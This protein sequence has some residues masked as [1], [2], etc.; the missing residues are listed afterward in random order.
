MK[1]KGLDDKLAL[2][3]E[4]LDH[5]ETDYRDEQERMK[6]REALMDG[7]K[8]ILSPDGT[9]SRK[10]AK[11]VRNV[12]LEMVETQ[13]DSSIPPPKVTALREEDEELATIIEAM[14]RNVLDRLQFERMNDEA[15]RI[16]PTQGGHGMLA[17]WRSTVSGRGWMGDLSVTMLHPRKIVPQ[18]G[19][20]QVQEMDYIFIKDAVTKRQVKE[21][22]HVNVDGEREDDPDARAVGASALASD[23]L[24]TLVTVYYRNEHG[25]I[26]R[27]RFVGDTVCEDMEDYQIRRVKE[28]RACGAIGNGKKCRY[29]GAKKFDEK[30]LEYEELT[31]DIVTERGNVIPM[32]S[33]EVD[34]F[35]QT[36]MED[37]P[38]E[39]PELLGGGEMLLPQLA[40]GG[41]EAPVMLRPQ[42]PKMGKT[43]IPYY[44]PDVFPVVIRKNVSR[45]GK[46]LGGS[47]IDAIEDQQNE[48]NKL[49]TKISEKVLGGGSFTTT[50][51]GA[52][53]VVTDEDNRVVEVEKPSDLEMFRTF[54]TQVDISQ[55]MAMQRT[56]YEEARET[57]G[58]T[59]S[60]Q[61]RRDPTATSKVAKEFS[62]QRAAGRFESKH[63]MKNALFAD[64]FEIIFKFMLAYADE[65]RPIRTWN[66]KGE[67][68]YKIFDRHD[69][70]YQDEAGEW[71]YNTDFL[72]SCDTV[73][74][75][76]GD[77]QAMWQET[78]M[79]FESGAMGA[80][81]D[82][83]TLIRFWRQMEKLH[84]PMASEMR[85]AMEQEL[86]EQ[87]T[88][89]AVQTS[90]RMNGGGM[91][92]TNGGIML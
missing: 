19:I 88:M 16:S 83:K 91:P 92:V 1:T 37:M 78:R 38:G 70:L 7:S 73:A 74:P 56:I 20:Y 85:T 29:C 87:Q 90:M 48:L 12:C 25:G 86:Q 13:I 39:E 80:P 3:Q 54:N 36:V 81:N 22:Y 18:P 75:L 47:D 45:P 10:K 43:R 89:Q 8:V 63:V 26:G 72:F 5:A 11:H 9:V 2:W 33:A 49:G 41:M 84:Y 34:A 32:E 61:G 31:E 64:L 51:K 50:P 17:D 35:G 52:L 65:P 79:N 68:E 62:A 42:R 60:L 15:E 27:F 23:E 21:R 59:D 69:F 28:C 76:A 6:R 40:P 4:R 14:L 30:L 77:R 66:D 71:H 82:L 24:V 44:K 57:L 53:V 58:V 46:F 55:D 67:K